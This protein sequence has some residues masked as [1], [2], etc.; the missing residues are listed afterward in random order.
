MGIWAL[1]KTEVEATALATAMRSPMRPREA[2]ES[3]YRI[4]GCDDLFD[5]FNRAHRT[6]ADADVRCLV[7]NR[8]N[9]VYFTGQP[10]SAICNERTGDILEEITASFSNSDHDIFHEIATLKTEQQALRYLQWAI[11]IK[12]EDLHL[13]SIEKDG[14]GQDYIARKPDG[15]FVR[16]EAL[17]SVALDVDVSNNDKYQEIFP[18]VGPSL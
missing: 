18:T 5:G 4:F 12:D 11:E 8:I 16:L 3:L 14:S 6:N 1:P 9:Q 7:I 15:N 10:L 13:Y 17:F 2:E